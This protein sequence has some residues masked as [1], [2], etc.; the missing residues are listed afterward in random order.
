M[1]GFHAKSDLNPW[2]APEHYTYYQDVQKNKTD[3]LL[4]ILLQEQGPVAAV[5]GLLKANEEFGTSECKMT[6][7]AQVSRYLLVK[8]YEKALD[9]IETMYD[10]SDPQSPYIGT[11]LSGYNYLK[12]SV[13]YIALLKKM[14]LPVD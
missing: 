3:G 8:D 4:E 1:N 6:Q 14:N 10:T 5:E 12:D 11:N 13:R 7:S 2:K 9:H